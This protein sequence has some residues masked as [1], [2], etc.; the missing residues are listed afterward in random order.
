MPHER[1]GVL[2]DVHLDEHQRLTATVE[3]ARINEAMAAL[4]EL[5][6]TALT[7]S[8]ASLEDL[9]LRQY[10]DTGENTR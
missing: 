10:G 4:T 5:G 1:L 8:P 9:F 2:H 3:P 6:M 7:V